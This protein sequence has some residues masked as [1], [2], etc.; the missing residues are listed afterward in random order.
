MSEES[1][2]N[3]KQDREMQKARHD[4]FWISLRREFEIMPDYEDRIAEENDNLRADYA[5]ALGDIKGLRAELAAMTERRDTLLRIVRYIRHQRNEHIMDE[6]QT[7]TNTRPQ[8]RATKE[9]SNMRRAIRRR[10]ARNG[11]TD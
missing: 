10:E 8:D 4:D 11:H 1:W 5:K 7:W 2:K 9:D 6:Y 3:W